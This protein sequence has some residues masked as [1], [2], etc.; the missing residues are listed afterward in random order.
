M[1]DFT[2]NKLGRISEFLDNSVTPVAISKLFSRTEEELAK[3]K[4][5][6]RDIGRIEKLLFANTNIYHVKT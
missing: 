5:L 6:R 1:I 2:S 3:Q 4:D